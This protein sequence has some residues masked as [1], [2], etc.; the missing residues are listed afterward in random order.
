MRRGPA[1]RPLRWSLG[2]EGFSV[3]D[4]VAV[5]EDGRDDRERYRML[6]RDLPRRFHAAGRTAQAFSLQQAPKLTRTRWDA[7]LAAVAEHMAIL[8]DLPIPDWVDDP[9]RFL[10]IPW[11]P[12]HRLPALYAT[13]FIDSPGA[14]VRHGTLVDPSELNSRG[15]EREYGSLIGR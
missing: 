9:E 6:I 14:F 11:M 3:A 1:G 8:H 10:R 2:S 7:L 5:I 13:A 15:G 4:Y 12:L